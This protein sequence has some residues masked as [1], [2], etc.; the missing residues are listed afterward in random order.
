[1]VKFILL[2]LLQN[3]NEEPGCLSKHADVEENFPFCGMDW[4][5][6]RLCINILILLGDLERL[7]L[8]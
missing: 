6:S 7:V 4:D 8:S 2:T 1:M 3:I 5:T